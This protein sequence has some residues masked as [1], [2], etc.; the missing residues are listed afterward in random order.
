MYNFHQ[1]ESKPTKK[2]YFG[3]IHA[4]FSS[5][6]RLLTEVAICLNMR[7]AGG[8]IYLY[9]WA[10]YL[11]QPTKYSQKFLIVLFILEKIDSHW[12]LE[13]FWPLGRVTHGQWWSTPKMIGI[14][15]A[16]V[17]FVFRPQM[18]KMKMSNE[19][20]FWYTKE[21]GTEV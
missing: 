2:E 3:H 19:N 7:V 20:V 16:C 1:F 11:L 6:F 14:V 12:S 8:K 15:L 4:I 21:E 13:A 9:V 17:F 10:I 18:P 5:I